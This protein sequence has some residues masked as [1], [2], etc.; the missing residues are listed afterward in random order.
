MINENVLRIEMNIGSLC[1]FRCRYCFENGDDK[2]YA[3]T[4]TSWENLFR[5]AKYLHWLKAAKYRD[6]EFFITIFGGEPLMQLDNVEHFIRSV[7]SIAQCIA[8]T[9]NGALVPKYA[10]RLLALKRFRGRPLIK[11]CTSYDFVNQ[12]E[13]RCAGS[14]ESVRDS[15]RWLYNNGLLS[16]TNTVFSAKNLHRM[17]EV[18]FDFEELRKE[19]PSL[20]CSFNIDRWGDLSGIDEGSVRASMQKIKEYMDPRPEIRFYYNSNVGIDRGCLK[21]KD[22]FYSNILLSY[23]DDGSIYPGYDVPYES[24]AVKN[25]LYVGHVSE[26]FEELEA[27]REAMLAGI[28]ENYPPACRSCTAPCRLFP[29]RVIK[30]SFDQWWDMPPE[31]HC[32]VSRLIGEYFRVPEDH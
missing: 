1:N 6:Y 12:N 13:T 5:F 7:A 2:D 8:F 25:L 3:P 29:W 32:R 23:C 16:K 22:C 4:K 17:H 31:G 10:D 26:P 11:I 24:E 9:T 15:I 18:F 19:L 20:Q 30:D 28:P 27:K 21:L 14:Y